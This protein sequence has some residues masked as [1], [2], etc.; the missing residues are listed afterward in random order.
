MAKKT[1][2]AKARTMYARLVRNNKGKRPTRQAVMK[3]LTGSKFSMSTKG[4]SSYYGTM[5]DIPLTD[6]A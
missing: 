3:V 2:A 5:K 1:A 6:L 4:A